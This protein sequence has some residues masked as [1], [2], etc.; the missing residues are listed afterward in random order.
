MKASGK[1]VLFGASRAPEGDTETKGEMVLPLM[2][3]NLLENRHRL[4]LDDSVQSRSE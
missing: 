4:H 3:E 2:M 1:M